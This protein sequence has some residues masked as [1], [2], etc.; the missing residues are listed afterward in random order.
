MPGTLII[1][2]IK[3][4]DFIDE[5]LNCLFDSGVAVRT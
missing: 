5:T 1:S 3:V 2:I 4:F